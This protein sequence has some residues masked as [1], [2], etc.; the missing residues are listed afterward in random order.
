MKESIKGNRQ[1][2]SSKPGVG[3]YN[4]DQYS[5]EVKLTHDRNK[6]KALQLKV[7]RA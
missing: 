1:V 6:F 3:H 5:T 4:K 2:N 7:G